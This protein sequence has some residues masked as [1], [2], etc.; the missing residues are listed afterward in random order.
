MEK[1][2]EGSRKIKEEGKAMKGREKEEKKK[3]EIVFRERKKVNTLALT[4]FECFF[5][6][7]FNIFNI[8][9]LGSGDLSAS[10]PSVTSDEK[11]AKRAHIILEII[12][13]EHAYI[14]FLTV[15]IDVS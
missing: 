11:R 4:Y 8:F 1:V 12:N 3:Q 9:S 7:F 10:T 6:F 5:F 13:T 14:D 15:W 2:R